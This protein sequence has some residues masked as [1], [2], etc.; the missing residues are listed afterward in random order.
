MG[1][2]KY[3]Y[4]GYETTI[5]YDDYDDI[6]YGRVENIKDLVSFENA[7]LEFIENEFYSAVDDYLNYCNDL[8]QKP[9]ICKGVN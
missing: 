5:H 7:K 4:K 3:F 6:Y 2:I 8:G 1:Q 9:N